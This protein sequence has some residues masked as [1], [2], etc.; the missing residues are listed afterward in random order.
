MAQADKVLASVAQQG[1]GKLPR[2]RSER[3][4]AV[5]AR[6]TSPRNLDLFKNR[7][8]PLDARFPKAV[9]YVGAI[10]AISKLYYAGFLKKDVSG[11]ELVELFG[12]MLRTTVVLLEL[13][14]EFM[15][16]IPKDDPNYQIRMQGMGQVR[17]G[18]TQAVTGALVM[19]TERE[20]YRTN[21][22]ARL[23]DYMKETLPAIVPRLSPAQRTEILRQ[24]EKLTNDSAL[25]DLQPGLG[26]LHSKVKASVEKGGAP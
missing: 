8:L 17:G 10:N 12:A 1:H 20:N 16:T 3:S 25:K 22:R 26:E 14:D 24:L 6:L 13:T 4:G 11:G 15:T 9:E 7:T 18:L 19:L 5:F 2:Y 21:E 23:I